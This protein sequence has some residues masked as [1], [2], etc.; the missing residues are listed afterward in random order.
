VLASAQEPDIR[1]Y[2]TRPDPT[3][4][5]A[6]AYVAQ[7][8]AAWERDER[9]T[10]A[11]CE[12][13]TGEMLGE[14]DLS[15]LDLDRGAAEIG[16]WALPAARGR[17]LATTAVSSVLRFAFG[18]LGL[19]RVTYMWA[20]DNHASAA[21]ARRCGFVEEGLLRGAWMIDGVHVDMHVASRLATDS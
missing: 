21:V 1:R 12:P 7:R 20:V 19:H 3:P 4:A 14:V 5:A 11:V 10:W 13:T 17:G 9:Y 18:G 2:R 6:T 8:A 16:V 15:R